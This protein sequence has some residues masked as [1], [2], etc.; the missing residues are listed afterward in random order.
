MP[1]CIGE[2]NGNPLQYSSL[3]NPRDGGAW[4]PAT[5]GVTE[6]DTTEGTWQQHHS[7]FSCS[8]ISFI[9]S[10]HTLLGPLDCHPV[11]NFFFHARRSSWWVSG[12]SQQGTDLTRPLSRLNPAIVSYCRREKSQIHLLF[13]VPAKLFPKWLARC[14][15]GKVPAC[16]CRR[17][18]L[19]PWVRKIPWRRKWQ[20]TSAFLPEKSHRQRSMVGYSP[21]GHKRV[22]HNIGT[23]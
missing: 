15:S 17:H 2:G 18:G 13:V 4:R 9:M 8:S 14:L 23:Q 12:W 5:Y 22:R 7:H 11:P 21:W 10:S 3:E 6:S 19:D 20:P 16:Q 1:A